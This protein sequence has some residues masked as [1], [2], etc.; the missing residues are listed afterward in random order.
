MATQTAAEL[1]NALHAHGLHLF[2]GGTNLEGVEL[3]AP[4]ALLAGL[5]R[6]EDARLR[7]ALIALFLYRPSIVEAIPEALKDLEPYAQMTLKLFYTAAVTLQPLYTEK[8]KAFLP[9]QEALPDIFS[10]ELG[11]PAESSPLERLAHLSHHHRKLTGVAANWTGT[12]RYAAERLL[13]RLEKEAAWA[14]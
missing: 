14:T 13:T 2:P 6:Q 3:M 12:Y 1:V 5:A 9:N 7:M 11:I 4:E 8:L 10:Q